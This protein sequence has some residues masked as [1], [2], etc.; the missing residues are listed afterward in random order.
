MSL[1]VTQGTALFTGTSNTQTLTNIG[2]NVL[3]VAVVHN[4]GLPSSITWNGT[5]LVYKNGGD[6]GG[7]TS[8]VWALDSGVA[9]GT[10]DLI[11]NKS[12]AE[13]CSFAWYF[14]SSGDAIGA[15]A[16]SNGFGTLAGSTLA[17]TGQRG[18]FVFSA[19]WSGNPPITANGGQTTDFSNVGGSRKQGGA[20][21]AYALS[22]DP[23]VSWTLN[24]SDAWA[25]AAIEVPARP[26]TFKSPSGGVATYGSFA[27]A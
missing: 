1:I 10:A 17:T 20:H 11:V 27:S 23:D 4:G 9:T 21:I 19:M 24:S 13:T 25:W 16:G 2:G 7:N 3:V 8:S 18:G 22:D 5:N 15:T 14:V 6:S 12:G 26:S